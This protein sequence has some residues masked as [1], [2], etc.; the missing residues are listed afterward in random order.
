M[1]LK[2][3][4]DKYLEE[5][6]LLLFIDDVKIDSINKNFIN[7]I[8]PENINKKVIYSG[9]ELEYD[10]LIY[11]KKNRIL[12]LD[13]E[14]DIK[15]SL[16]KKEFLKLEVVKSIVNITK[17]NFTNELLNCEEIE[18]PIFET[19]VTQSY[20]G[21]IESKIYMKYYL[22]QIDFICIYNKTYNDYN[23]ALIETSHSKSILENNKD[24]LLKLQNLYDEQIETSILID[25][26]L[27]K[28]E[29]LFNG[30]IVLNELSEHYTPYNKYIKIID[31][32][33]KSFTIISNGEYIV[34][35]DNVFVNNRI[36]EDINIPKKFKGSY[37][38]MLYKFYD[39]LL[40]YSQISDADDIIKCIKNDIKENYSKLL[41]SERTDEFYNIIE[42]GIVFINKDTATKFDK[43]I[44]DYV[45]FVVKDI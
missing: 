13:I 26:V 15:I 4:I 30:N 10:K 33:N 38:E 32:F 18:Y 25:G 8:V 6:N 27:Y 21:S 14:K 11:N 1:I 42:Q 12:Y 40:Q 35:D 37:Y 17:H 7:I 31:L 23:T 34:Y 28:F 5:T 9:I 16:T 41:E 45:D 20:D 19:S 39:I 24:V 29:Y 3:E 22:E 2:N 43:K 36:C 44:I